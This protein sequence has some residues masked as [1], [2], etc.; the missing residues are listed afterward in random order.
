MPAT[1][2]TGAFRHLDQR[3]AS[4]RDLE[5]GAPTTPQSTDREPDFPAMTLVDEASEHLAPAREGVI[6]LDSPVAHVGPGDAEEAANPPPPQTTL[7]EQSRRPRGYLTE[8]WRP[9]VRVLLPFA[10][11]FYLTNLFRTINA[12]IS[13]QLTSDLALGA[14]DLGLLTSVY[15]LTFAA[16]Q[17]PIGILL[18]RYC[19]RAVENGFVVVAA[20]RPPPVR[21]GKRVLPPPLA[22]ALDRGCGLGGGTV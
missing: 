19:P 17:I 18:D 10:V 8:K 11:G 22:P 3:V 16:A 12:L 20:G 15:F 6:P 4:T 14:A 1:K 9:I 7:R 2:L 21:P 13:N 5:V